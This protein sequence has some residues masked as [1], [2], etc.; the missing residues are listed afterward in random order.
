MPE[1]IEI[2][3]IKEN[4]NNREY[5]LEAVSKQGA[6]LDFA[7]ESFKDDK[8]I[9]LAAIK[10]NPEALEFASDRLKSDREVVYSSVSKVRMDIL[11]YRRRVIKGQRVINISFKS[12]RTSSILCEF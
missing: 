12:Y 10:N 9:V 11:L 3:R 4:Y 5:V 6:L 7:D 2:T 1:P 8:E